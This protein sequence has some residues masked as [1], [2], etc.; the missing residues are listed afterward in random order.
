MNYT[1]LDID[2]FFFILSKLNTNVT[3]LFVLMEVPAYTIQG[4]HIVK[5]QRGG[6][7]E[8]AKGHSEMMP[9]LSAN[10]QL[11]KLYCYGHNI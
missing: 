8:M 11:L 1:K 5:P 10:L 3:T 4:V 7:S 9:I 2:G 6:T